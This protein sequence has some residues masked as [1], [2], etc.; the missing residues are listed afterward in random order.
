MFLKM[1]IIE[2]NDDDET[3]D[4]TLSNNK[5]AS[6]D[7]L[8]V[9]LLLSRSIEMMRQSSYYACEYTLWEKKKFSP[10]QSKEEKM[11]RVFCGTLN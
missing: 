1:R 8:I 3:E 6:S 4:A 2:T 5:G 11:F 9:L 7:V 10:R